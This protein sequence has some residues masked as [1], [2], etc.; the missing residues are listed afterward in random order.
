[1]IRLNKFYLDLNVLNIFSVEIKQVF[2]IGSYKKFGFL[3][4]T[5]FFYLFF[6]NKF[7]GLEDFIYVN[8][9]VSYDL[10][11]KISDFIK[12]KRIKKTYEG[13]RHRLGLSVRGQRTHSNS[14]TQRFKF[15]RH[16]L[17]KKTIYVN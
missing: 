13:I 5:R 10:R 2:G 7:N 1:M 11:Q 15:K 3:K 12:R 17:K 6:I 14:K 8:F 16:N 9:V 4:N